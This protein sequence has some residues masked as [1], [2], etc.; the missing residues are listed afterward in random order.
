MLFLDYK[1]IRKAVFQLFGLTIFI[2]NFCVFNA[3]AQGQKS[4]KIGF[5]TCGT[6]KERLASAAFE[7]QKNGNPD[8]YLVII[9]GAMKGEKLSSNSQRIQ[10]AIGYLDY[11]AVKTER[12][13]FGTGNPKTESGYL[14]LYINGVLYTEI[15]TRKNGKLCWCEGDAFDF[16]VK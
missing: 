6:G 4:D 3:A 8:T 16:K 11:M 10:Q 7:F 2:V 12:I 1:K 15:I 9:G 14:R 5:D 13:V